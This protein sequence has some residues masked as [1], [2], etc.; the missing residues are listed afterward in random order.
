VRAF[1]T[2]A[3]G[4][5]GSHLVEALLA[6][7]DDVAALVRSPAK[8]DR[9]FTER[10]PRYVRGDL[11]S[12]QALDDGVQDVDV[13]FHVAGVTSA[14]GPAEFEE[15]NRGGTER[16]IDAIRARG[17]SLDRLLYV[18]SLSAAGPAKRGSVLTEQDP[19]R[20][21][22]AYGRTKL[23]GERAA[24]DSGLPAT[25]VR[26]PAVYGPRDVEVRRVF[27]FARYGIA[28]V[29]DDGGQE[30]TFV[31]VDDLVAAMIAAVE[32]GRVGAT[33]YACH[34]EVITSEQ[35][36]VAA[37]EAVSAV[38][39]GTPRRPRITLRVPGWFARPALALNGAVVKLMGR[40]T[41]LSSDKVD[42]LLAPSW[43]CS[44]AALEADT[45][46]QAEVPLA[47]GLR[48]TARWLQEHGLL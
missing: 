48:R 9:L 27:S 10:K 41:V 4:F 26:P 14:R 33:Y 15:I 43:A 13:V 18:S 42:E 37:S 35:F 28:P 24:L 20:P 17:G 29:F 21:I 6:R 36:V 38:R 2:G 7:G 1:V 8:A 32:R 39:S 40:T 34:P 44:P 5:V 19:P 22:S 30:L 16:V 12:R 47:D 3:T 11:S 23:A 45:G 25:V 46:W 31:Y